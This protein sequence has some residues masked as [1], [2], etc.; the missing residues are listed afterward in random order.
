[1]PTKIVAGV[2]VNKETSLEDL[3]STVHTEAGA[4]NV[5]HALKGF[6][7]LTAGESSTVSTAFHTI[8][9]LEET[10]IT[11]INNVG[12]D[13]LSSTV[14][15]AGSVIYGVFTDVNVVSGNAICYI[16]GNYA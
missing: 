12:G 11:A 7:L 14:L 5:E 1:M 4:N 15:P 16:L 8:Q 2:T 9:F 10:T 13:N 3:I 6:E